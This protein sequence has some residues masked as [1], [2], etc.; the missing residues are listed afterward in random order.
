ME[1][2]LTQ[3]AKLQFACIF[4]VCSNDP[5]ITDIYVSSTYQRLLSMR[6]V[7]LRAKYKQFKNGKVKNPS[8]CILM[9]DKHGGF[10]DFHIELIV[11]CPCDNEMEL[12][13]IENSYIRSMDCVN[14]HKSVIKTGEER[15]EAKIEYDKKYY[16]ERKAELAVYKKEYRIHKKNL[17]LDGGATK[18]PVE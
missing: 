12:R 14:K 3:S 18:P 11:S 9:F 13:A 1:D 2:T 15:K 10:D 8:P 6:M 16:E 5:E 4:K 17:G 7:G